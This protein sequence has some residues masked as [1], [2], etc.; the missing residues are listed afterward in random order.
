MI[1]R[2]ATSSTL[3]EI[4]LR[5]VFDMIRAQ[6]PVSRAEI[7]RRSG[8]SKPTVSAL[9]QDLLDLGL[10]EETVRD[11]LGPT[12]G[13][14]FFAPGPRPRTCSRWTSARGTCAGPSPTWRATSCCAATPRSKG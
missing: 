4:N 14:L 11:E 10:V 9:L 3:R 8:I 6:A 2:P 12:Y 5:T 13:A 1:A 7:A